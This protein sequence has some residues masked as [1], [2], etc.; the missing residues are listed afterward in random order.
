MEGLHCAPTACANASTSKICLLCDKQVNAS[1][2][3]RFRIYFTCS[4]KVFP[5]LPSSHRDSGNFGKTPKIQTKLILN[6]PRTHAITLTNGKRENEKNKTL[7][8]LLSSFCLLK[9]EYLHKLRTRQRP[10]PGYWGGLQGFGV[11]GKVVN[12][13]VHHQYRSPP[14]IGPLK[15]GGGGYR[16]LV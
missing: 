8:R 11:N 15:G 5:K 13:T 3:G 7:N 4:F 16:V 9:P 2:L 14:G 1:A 6:Y 12:I 10:P